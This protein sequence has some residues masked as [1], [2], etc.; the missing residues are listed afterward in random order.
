MTDESVVPEKSQSYRMRMGSGVEAGVLFEDPMRRILT[1]AI[2]RWLPSRRE[3]V[4]TIDCD[5]VTARSDDQ[6]DVALPDEAHLRIDVAVARAM[7]EALGR[8]FGG[9]SDVQQTRRDLDAERGRVD[10]LIETLSGV[11]LR[12]EG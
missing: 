8:H 2:G 10:R 9:A 4:T 5:G 1:V 7:Y 11:V 12:R 6:V 3:Y